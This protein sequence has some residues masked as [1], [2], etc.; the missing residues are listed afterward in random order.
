M[1]YRHRSWHMGWIAATIAFVAAALL[2][3]DIAMHRGETLND[4]FGTANPGAVVATG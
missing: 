3:I 2:T 1:S 4:V